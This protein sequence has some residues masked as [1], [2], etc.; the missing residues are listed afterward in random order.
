MKWVNIGGRGFPPMGQR[1]GQPWLV[2]WY[3]PKPEQ[4]EYVMISASSNMNPV[5]MG[6]DGNPISIPIREHE[7]QHLHIDLARAL[8][9]YV[10]ANGWEVQGTGEE[11]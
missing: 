10:V 4:K 6:T 8:W 11:K 3:L 1:T 5:I 2:F 9:D 7:R